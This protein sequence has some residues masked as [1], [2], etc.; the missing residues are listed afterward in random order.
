MATTGPTF[1]TYIEVGGTSGEW[2]N[3]R[4]GRRRGVA[5]SIEA[6][7]VLK[8]SL[9]VWSTQEPNLMWNKLFVTEFLAPR[10]NT[11]LHQVSVPVPTS[12]ELAFKCFREVESIENFCIWCTRFD[13]KD[14]SWYFHCAWTMPKSGGRRNWWYRWNWTMRRFWC[15]WRLERRKINAYEKL[16]SLRKRKMKRNGADAL[17]GGYSGFGSS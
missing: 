14:S 7:R 1:F 9:V 2:S 17:N 6:I 4:K 3:T 8:F 11:S 10:T 13:W 5:F 12:Q 16:L 15:C